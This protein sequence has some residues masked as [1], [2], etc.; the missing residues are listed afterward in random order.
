MI[1]H[2][3][4]LDYAQESE[5]S[6]QTPLQ[7]N[8]CHPRSSACHDASQVVG[9]RVTGQRGGKLPTSWYYYCTDIA[10]QAPRW[11]PL[12]SSAREKRRRPY[13]R[14]SNRSSRA[15][16]TAV[17]S[18]NREAANRRRPQPRQQLHPPTQP[19]HR[20][21]RVLRVLMLPLEKLPMRANDEAGS[22]RGQPL[23]RI[24]LLSW[25]T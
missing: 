16:W 10:P 18:R 19:R 4:C 24:L 13:A 12:P 15:S 25:K 5:E 8:L 20:Y 17:A 22:R 3:D 9:V 6:L 11:T 2:N 7:R 21:R 23:L 1:N 14:P